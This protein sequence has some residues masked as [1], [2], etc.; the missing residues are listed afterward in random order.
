MDISDTR[1]RTKTKASPATSYRSN[2]VTNQNNTRNTQV[3]VS[4]LAVKLKEAQQAI[5]AARLNQQSFP[6]NNNVLT[7]QAQSNQEE[8]NSA[9]WEFEQ[10]SKPQLETIAMDPSNT[11][12][13]AEKAAAYEKWHALDQ[14]A[15][16]ELKRNALNDDN[17][18]TSFEAALYTHSQT[19]SELGKAMLPDD[20]LSQAQSHFESALQGV[21]LSAHTMNNQ[22]TQ[23][24]RLMV[25]D[26]FAG[27]EPKVH[28][29]AEGMSSHNLERSNYD[30]L[31]QKDRF[32]LADLYQYADQNDIDFEYIQ[33]LANDIG[34]YRRH[35][36]GK[37]LSNFNE[38][39]FNTEGQKLTVGFTQRDQASIDSLMNNGALSSSTLDAGFV[40]FITDPGLGALSHQG[41]YQFLAHI[42]EVTAGIATSDSATQFKTFTEASSINERYVIT[43]SEERMPLPEPDVTC[44][45]GVCEVTEKGRKNGV[46]LTQNTQMLAPPIEFKPAQFDTLL[47]LQSDPNT[48]KSVWFKWLL[49]K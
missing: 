8:I 32:M 38:G 21:N 26:L 30:F 17:A 34:N 31:T 1:W 2:T 15:L 24:Y 14:R 25:T 42:A 27:N 16:S 46:T 33:K 11:F 19:F 48:K 35:G 47:H 9:K 40:S 45:N 41:S 37:L 28:N 4:S 23:Y 20:Y 29:G 44:K 12:S 3:S 39:H 22:A 13:K 10:L 49:E 43:Q 18:M 7:W 5:D 6:Q 36:D